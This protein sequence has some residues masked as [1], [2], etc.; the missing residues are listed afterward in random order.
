[1]TDDVIKIGPLDL[2]PFYG[3]A[4]TVMREGSTV[5]DLLSWVATTQHET[6]PERW[7]IQCPHQPEITKRFTIKK[8]EEGTKARPVGGLVQNG[9]PIGDWL[10]VRRIE[11]NG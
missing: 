5:N 2:K 8:K 3:G 9:C 7:L 11:H 4:V 10:L 6:L 1:M